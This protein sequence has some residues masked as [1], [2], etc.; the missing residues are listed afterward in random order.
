MHNSF[1]KT[2]VCPKTKGPLEL[3]VSKQEGDVIKDGIL[4]NKKTNSEYKIQDGIPDFTYP[5]ELKASDKEFNEKYEANADF[6][7]IGMQW[8]FSSFYEEEENVRNKLISFLNIRPDDFILNL[9]C[10]S[11][12]DSKYILRHLNENGKLFNL[13]LSRNLLRIARDKLSGSKAQLDYFIGNGSYLPFAG[14][15]FDSVFHFGG[16]NIFSEKKRA[17]MEMTRVVKPGGRV[18]FGDESAAPWLSK[19]NFGKIITNA[20]PLYKHRPPLDLLPDNAQD[21]S[22]NY[23]LGNSFYIIA[24]TVGEPAKLNLDLPI[25]GKRGGTLRSRYEANHPKTIRNGK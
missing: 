4:I 5:D 3:E 10:G 15:I 18:V 19:K 16:I 21:V 11:G 24:F 12:S 17:I 6:Y 14:Q 7:D 9:G 20:N 25:P 8:L 1:I 22:L 13:D 23:V 2:I